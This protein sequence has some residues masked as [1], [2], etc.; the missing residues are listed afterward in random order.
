MSS[1]TT[2]HITHRAGHAHCQQ[3]QAH[4]VVQ[5]RDRKAAARHSSRQ[6]TA[7]WH[8]RNCLFFL[9]ELINLFDDDGDGG[10]RQ[11]FGVVA[12]FTQFLYDGKRL[13][14]ET[15]VAVNG[16]YAKDIVKFFKD[17]AS[18][19]KLIIVADKFQTGFD[20]PMLHTLYV[21]KRLR[22]SNAVQTIGSFIPT[23][24]RA[25]VCVRACAVVGCV[26]DI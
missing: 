12:A 3:S 5:G 20:E 22:G 13:V 19:V 24:A 7:R 2:P 18:S 4:H 26:R 17:P 8:S 1:G 23:F 21:D 14:K 9:H 11:R 10:G 16:K 6:G 25:V 15:D